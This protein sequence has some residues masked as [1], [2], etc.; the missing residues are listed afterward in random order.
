MPTTMVNDPLGI[1]YVFSDG[2]SAEFD[3]PNPRLTRDLA[4][5]LV[6]LIHPHVS[7]DSRS[8][9]DGYVAALRA[10]VRAL[11]EQGFT[12]GAD[13][14][15]RS[16]LAQFWMTGPTRLEAPPED[17]WRVTPGPAVSSTTGC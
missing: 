10:M 2:R 4:T 9:V 1:C 12:G 7:A 14:L 15:R 11:A 8:T 13:G 16:Q 3:L 17:W 5:G 6:E